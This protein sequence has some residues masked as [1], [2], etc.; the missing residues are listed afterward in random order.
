MNIK[1]LLFLVLV[2]ILCIII[3]REYFRPILLRF[4]NKIKIT[5]Y[6]EKVY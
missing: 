5:F 3:M 2:S 1:D 4:V 6:L